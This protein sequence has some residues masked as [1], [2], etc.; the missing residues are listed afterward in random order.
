VANW[1]VHRISQ[2]FMSLRLD[3]GIEPHGD[4]PA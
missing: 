1:I 4:E 2:T 3:T